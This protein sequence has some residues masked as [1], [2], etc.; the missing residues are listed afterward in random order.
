VMH[1]SLK[2]CVVDV[3]IGSGALGV[4]LLRDY[5]LSHYIGVD[6]AQR[7]LDAARENL[8]AHGYRESERQGDAHARTFSLTLAPTDFSRYSRCSLLVCQAAMQH[9]PSREYTI[10]W[11]RNV[12]ASGVRWLMLQPRYSATPVFSEWATPG[13]RSNNVTLGARFDANWILE[14]MR[15]YVLRWSSPRYSTYIFYAFE[16]REGARGAELGGSG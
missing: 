9:F 14:H 11:L 2:P 5:N 6:I 4:L 1:R 16:R 15:N 12:D 7:Q 13:S 10:A 3:G 8:L